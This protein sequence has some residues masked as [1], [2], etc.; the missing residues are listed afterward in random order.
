MKISTK[1]GDKGMCSLMF[2]ERVSKASMRVKTYGNI[3]EL[4]AALG[5]ARAFCADSNLNE[6][7]LDVQNALIH[8]MTELATSPKN[9][10]L[11]SEKNI[12]VLT[13]KDLDKIES[14]ISEI[15]ESGD[16][17]KGWKMAGT[18][19][20]EANLN[21][22]R[23]ICRK[24]ERSLVELENSEGCFNEINLKYLNR[25]SDL[26]YLWSLLALKGK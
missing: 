21:F 4:C 12:E 3:D 20:F 8:L 16:T 13:Q 18:N 17:F 5:L 24:A 11:L 22:A 19:P 1:K 25:L 7:I 6:K 14:Q 10:H 2:N 9:H 23:T 26:I 15:E